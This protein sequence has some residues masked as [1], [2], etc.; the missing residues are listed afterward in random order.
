MQLPFWKDLTERERETVQRSAVTRRYEKGALIH[1]G[2]SECLGLVL[3][4]SGELRTYLLSDE[5]REVTLFRLYAGD[6]CVLSASCVISQ[7][8]FDTQMTAQRDTEVLIIPANIVAMLKE[9]NL[10]VRCCLYELATARFSDV[11][12]AMQQLL[13]KGLDRR[14]A[15]FLL[16]EA[17]RTGSDTKGL[18]ILAAFLGG[19]VV[20]AAAGI[21]FAPESGE[22]TRSKIADALRK[23]GIKLSRT[24]ME[25]LVDEIAAEVKE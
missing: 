25:N 6:L 3:V 19:A 16:S 9:Q 13:F 8:T 11:M 14:L 10:A 22:D 21:L 18:S 24:D 5:G 12:W 17:E 15:G 7:I 1:D 2:G 20:G 4:L 23:R